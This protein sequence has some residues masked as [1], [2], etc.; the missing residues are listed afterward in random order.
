MEQPHGQGDGNPRLHADIDPPWTGLSLEPRHIA[1]GRGS[2]ACSV[3]GW[4]WGPWSWA[5]QGPS[6]DWASP[7]T[8]RWE[9][10]A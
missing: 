1:L 6:G 3:L 9:V 2:W 8:G 5:L 4:G 10:Q 7:Q